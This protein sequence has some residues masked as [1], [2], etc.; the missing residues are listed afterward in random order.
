M[1]IIINIMNKSQTRDKV[2]FKMEGMKPE[3]IIYNGENLKK[4]RKARRLNQDDL[5][6]RAG[7]SRSQIAKME[8][9][10]IN[11]S[12]KILEQIGSVLNVEWLIPPKK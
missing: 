7:L 9:E 4:V 11:P 10:T 3:R 12:V 8:A 6:D 5:S 1:C 2:V